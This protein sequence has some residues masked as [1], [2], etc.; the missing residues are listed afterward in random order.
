MRRRRRKH[1]ERAE[2]TRKSGCSN[3]CAYSNPG[4]CDAVADP[5]RRNPLANTNG[6]AEGRNAESNPNADSA[7]S[8]ADALDDDSS[9][10]G[11]PDEWECQSAARHQHGAR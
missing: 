1:S 3:R 10:R 2:R 8:N 6:D 9:S 5:R 4:R 11:R 7:A